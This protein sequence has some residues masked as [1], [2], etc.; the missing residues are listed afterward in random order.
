MRS[1]A[2]VLPHNAKWDSLRVAGVY[3]YLVG[4]LAWLSTRVKRAGFVGRLLAR[5]AIDRTH[6]SGH[7][8]EAVSDRPVPNGSELAECFAAE[9]AAK[10]PNSDVEL[11]FADDPEVRH[12]IAVDVDKP[13]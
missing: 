9:P 2:A 5:D 12:T 3:L 6:G 13:G 7:E 8:G 1:T 10:L 4:L 11:V